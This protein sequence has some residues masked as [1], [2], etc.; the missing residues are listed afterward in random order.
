MNCKKSVFLLTV[1]PSIVLLTACAS[2]GNTGHHNDHQTGM[3]VPQKLT[4]EFSTDPNPVV[5]NQAARLI[6]HVSQNGQPIA[7]A[8][9]EMEIWREGDSQHEK[10]KA[11]ADQNGAYV[12]Q[13]TFGQAGHYHVT[14]HT[15]ARGVHQMP[16]KDFQVESAR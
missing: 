9:I 12:V 3:D 5:V 7:D 6:E 2:Q 4:I 8:T 14:L 15:T 13:K 16:T 1:V 11:A 10:V